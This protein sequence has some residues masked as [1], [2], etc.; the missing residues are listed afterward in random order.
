MIRDPRRAR[1][2]VTARTATVGAT[3][4]VSA[5]ASA[6]ISVSAAT[7]KPTATSPFLAGMDADV[8]DPFPRSGSG[9]VEVPQVLGRGHPS[10][11]STDRPTRHTRTAYPAPGTGHRG[12]RP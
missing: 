10:G 11:V 1:S 8:V 9:A 12:P 7:K 5:T 4:S 6:V 2:P 3:A